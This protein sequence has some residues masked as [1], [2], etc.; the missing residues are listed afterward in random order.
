M[1]RSRTF[2]GL[3]LS[4]SLFFTALAALAPNLSL[5]AYY[6]AND[7]AGID[8]SNIINHSFRSPYLFG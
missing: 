8:C 6:T 5:A 3:V 2:K 4:F 1:K 7:F